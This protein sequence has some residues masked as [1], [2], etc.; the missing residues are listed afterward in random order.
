MILKQTQVVGVTHP[1]REQPLP[2]TVRV[3]PAHQR[4]R[5]ALQGVVTVDLILQAKRQLIAQPDY[6]ATFS[7][8]WVYLDVTTLS[9]LPEEM[10]RLVDT[11]VELIEAGYI[12]RGRVAVVVRRESLIG[13][14]HLYKH[15]M[16]RGAGQTVEVFGSVAAAEAWLSTATNG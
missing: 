10:N 7:Q 6:E 9:I 5:I 1:Q 4:S 14:A 13:A 11:A 15:A 3:E 2:Y 12:T 16:A 8:L